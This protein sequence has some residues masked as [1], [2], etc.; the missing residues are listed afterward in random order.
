MLIE[1]CITQLESNRE[2]FPERGFSDAVSSDAVRIPNLSFVFIA[3][4]ICAHLR[5]GILRN[6]AERGNIDR[7]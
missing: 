2:G 6:Q 4:F 3:Y 7:P 5:G 1:V